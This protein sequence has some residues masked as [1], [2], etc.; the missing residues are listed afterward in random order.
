MEGRNVSPAEQIKLFSLLVLD[1]VILLVTMFNFSLSCRFLFKNLGFFSKIAQLI[2][3]TTSISSQHKNN[4]E[5]FSFEN[6]IIAVVILSFSYIV[7][8]ANKAKII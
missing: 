1:I 5:N 4:T 7:H 2:Q 6:E 3:R 8:T